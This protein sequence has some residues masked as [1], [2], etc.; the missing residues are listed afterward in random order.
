VL[1]GVKVKAGVDVG[2]GK[3]WDVSWHPSKKMVVK[4]RNSS[5]ENRIRLFMIAPIFLL[6]AQENVK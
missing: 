4:P 1:A 2:A 5:A 3:A 6:S